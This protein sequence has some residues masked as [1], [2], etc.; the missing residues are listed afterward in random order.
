MS[1][2]PGIAG[3]RSGFIKLGVIF[4][5]AALFLVL[6]PSVSHWTDARAMGEL[7]RAR[8]FGGPLG[9]LA[10]TSVLTFAGLPRLVFFAL[11]G[12]LLGFGEGFAIALSGSLMG[13]F[14][15]FGLLRWSGRDWIANRFGKGGLSRITA[16]E[17]NVISVFMVRQLPVSSLFIN[18]GLAMS[19]V[20][21][22]AFLMGS[23][24]G[25]IPQGAAA[26]LI[27]SGG[28]K[29]SLMD[30]SLQLAG[31]AVVIIVMAV[32]AWRS[33]SGGRSEVEA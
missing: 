3:G 15:I 31:A 19:R 29:H 32:W 7:L 1:D 2:D 28:S 14:A 24:L 11:A 13:S 17:P 16:V 25:F 33:K 12:F 6:H 30:G 4:V 27:G 23:L 21:S 20:K 22:P 9:L 10:V 8:G 5:V 18:A 26:A